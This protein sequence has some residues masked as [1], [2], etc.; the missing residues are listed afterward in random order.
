M[1]KIILLGLA[2]LLVSQNLN[3]Q[4][5]G[6]NKLGSWY[7]FF[8]NHRLNDKYSIHAE[9]QLRFFEPASNFFQLLPRVGL[10]YHITSYSSVTAGYALIPTSSYEKSEE[11]RTT[12]LEHRI[13][14]QFFLKNFIDRV[15]IN[16]RYR[17]EQQWIEVSTNQSTT[18][19]FRPRIRYQ[20]TVQVPINNDEIT[21][22]TIFLS[23]YN[24]IFMRFNKD[25][26]FD[27]N[28]LYFAL[29]YKLNKNVSIQAGYLSH[30]IG[31]TQFDRLQFALFL[32][33]SKKNKKSDSLD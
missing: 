25:Q 8:L 24:E 23:A 4:E 6:Q 19:I 5:T 1:K 10:N 15:R 32:N 27:Q 11:L 29:G 13:W 17:F 18:H 7:M 22:K 16:H 33:T 30:W 31:S 12:S 3:A 26:L 9:T 20:L 2:T 28:R 14:Q 21:D